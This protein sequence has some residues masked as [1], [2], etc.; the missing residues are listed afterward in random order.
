MH[1]IENVNINFPEEFRGSARA[2]MDSCAVLCEFFNQVL[3]VMEIV[4]SL[5]F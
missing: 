1:D 2:S 4:F 3:T 5:Y